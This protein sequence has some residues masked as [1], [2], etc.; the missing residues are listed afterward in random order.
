MFIVNILKTVFL[1]W[2]SAVSCLVSDHCKYLMCYSGISVLMPG[3]W[4]NPFV[5]EACFRLCANCRPESTH[6]GA[7]CTGAQAVWPVRGVPGLENRSHS[8]QLR[9]HGVRSEQRPLCTSIWIF[10]FLQFAIPLYG[11]IAESGWE[12]CS[13]LLKKVQKSFSV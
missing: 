1:S 7:L 5:Q 9:G 13:C 2:F 6:E 12:K 8:P 11:G 10:C 4:I 3:R